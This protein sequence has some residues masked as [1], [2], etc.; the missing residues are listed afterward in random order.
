M[1]AKYWRLGTYSY[2]SKLEKKW[3]KWVD[4]G[5]AESG[6]VLIIKQLMMMVLGALTEG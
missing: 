3:G 2:S 5:V 1:H 4:V 6:V